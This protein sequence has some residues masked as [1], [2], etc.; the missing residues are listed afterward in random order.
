MLE[1][2]SFRNRTADFVYFLLLGAISMII[3]TPLLPSSSSIPFLS[4]PL[5]FMLVYLWS[6]RNPHVRMNFMGLFNF[7]A[8]YLPWVLLGFTMLLNNIWP[9]G[10]LLGM[11]VGHVYYFLEDVYPR[12]ENG[13][14]VDGTRQQQQQQQRRRIL[15]TP[16]ILKRLFEDLDRDEGDPNLPDIPVLNATFEP[17]PQHHHDHPHQSQE[18]IN[19]RNGEDGERVNGDH[20]NNNGNI[21]NDNLHATPV[22]GM[23]ADDDSTPDGYAYRS[24]ASN[25]ADIRRR[26]VGNGEETTSSPSSSN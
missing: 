14:V 2:G 23:A 6:R 21:N 15:A 17:I 13:T 4:S 12:M 5:T 8:P 7:M 25:S 10:D 9:T 3:I 24:S 16:W 22:V 11:A 1:E 18:S 20:T 26:N 19:R